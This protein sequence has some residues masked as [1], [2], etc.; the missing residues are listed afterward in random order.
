MF[1]TNT[2]KNT[3]CQRMLKLM[4]TAVNEP[5]T[6][7]DTNNL[8]ILAMRHFIGKA[9]TDLSI[10]NSVLAHHALSLTQEEFNILKSIV[11]VSLS[12]PLP[13]NDSYI[14]SVVGPATK[15]KTGMVPGAYVLRINNDARQYVGRSS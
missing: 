7:Q 5:D 14:H 11:P 2:N 6:G 10:T 4:F 13:N 9:P 12:Y 3:R 8:Y 15:R 1:P